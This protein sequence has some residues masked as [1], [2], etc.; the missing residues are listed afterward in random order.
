MKNF[1]FLLS[2]S[3]ILCLTISLVGCGSDE[4]KTSKKESTVSK[5]S[6]K[7]GNDTDTS[8][9]QVDPPISQVEELTWET[10]ATDECPLMKNI[11]HRGMGAVAP[12]CTEMAYRLAAKAGY[13][14]A[15]NDLWFTA[16]GYP[17]MVHMKDLS[18][19]SN[20]KGNV[21]DVTLEY[22]KSL[23]FGNPNK[24]GDKYK[25][26]KVLTFEEW[27]A[28][29]KELNIKPYIDCKMF[30]ETSY[31]GKSGIQTCLDILDKYDMRRDA[32]WIVG[33][34]GAISVRCIYKDARIAVIATEN[35]TDEQFEQIKSLADPN[36]RDKI[37]L[38]MAS[39]AVT[40]ELVEKYNAVNVNVEAWTADE[41][42]YKNHARVISLYK[43]GVTGFTN[44]GV[45]VGKALKNAGVTW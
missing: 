6:E 42:A 5:T 37:V 13:K 41:N 4:E 20:G 24:F 19:T 22:L 26:T 25:G 3:L 21:T 1:K 18:V 44:D 8:T 9:S 31:S 10:F 16:D 29:C 35:P 34:S 40:K 11:F 28:L 30:A 2:I 38:N 15:E 36:D 23:D 33:I 43:M 12:E 7:E 32:T 17:V 27:I 39:G 45:N 14:Y